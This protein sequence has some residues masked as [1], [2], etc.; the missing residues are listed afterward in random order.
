ME[1]SKG[2]SAVHV[3]WVAYLSGDFRTQLILFSNRHTNALDAQQFK[4]ISILSRNVVKIVGLTTYL[5]TTG[6]EEILPKLK[7]AEYSVPH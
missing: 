5:K 2:W 4:E 1:L 3:E 7:N 6:L